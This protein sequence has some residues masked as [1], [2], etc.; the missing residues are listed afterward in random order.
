MEEKSYL[1]RVNSERCDQRYL[2]KVDDAE[3]ITRIE[4]MPTIGNERDIYERAGG[5]LKHWTITQVAG[6]KELPEQFRDMDPGSPRETEYL[7][8]LGSEE[9]RK[10]IKPGRREESQPTLVN[11]LNVSD[12]I[13]RDAFNNGTTVGDLFQQYQLVPASKTST[14]RYSQAM[15]G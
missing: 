1:M 15:R 9:C 10:N 12:P 14:T 5:F 7:K 11:R 8:Y 2:F 13:V 6:V 3:R 4:I